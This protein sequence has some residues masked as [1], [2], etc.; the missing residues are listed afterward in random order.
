VYGS[1]ID[2]ALVE[3]YFSAGVSRCVFRL[4]AAGANEVLAELDR[5]ATLA[6]QFTT[7]GAT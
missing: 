6:Q 5:A 2:P 1:R 4:P 7:A 3:S